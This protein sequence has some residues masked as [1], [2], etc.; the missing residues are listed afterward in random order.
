M[1]ESNLKTNIDNQELHPALP[2]K[3]P[4]PTLW[5]IAL[6]LGVVFCFWGILTSPAISGVGFLL[7]GL[8]IAGW[9]SEFLP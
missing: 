3:L 2:E 5:P 6:A 4:E 1:D 9:V 7:V 8:A